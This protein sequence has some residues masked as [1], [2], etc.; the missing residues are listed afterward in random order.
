MTSELTTIYSDA[1]TII[2]E[3]AR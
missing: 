2:A 1:A 3:S